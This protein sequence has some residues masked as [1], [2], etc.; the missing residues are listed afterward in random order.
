MI[1][2][3]THLLDPTPM[4]GA[5]F[6]GGVRNFDGY[7][8]AEATKAK[9]VGACVRARARAL[10]VGRNARACACARARSMSQATNVFKTGDLFFRSGDILR[11]DADGVLV[12]LQ[13]L[14]C[15]ASV[16]IR[17]AGFVYFVDRIGDTFRWKGENC[18]TSEIASVISASGLVTGDVNVFG[19]AVPKVSAAAAAA[20]TMRVH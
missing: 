8:S 6:A 4:I 3:A 1:G 10:V 13:W 14:S 11:R 16:V 9:Q 2:G 12:L 7:Q 5:Q 18:A 20:A 17:G 15:S 19:V